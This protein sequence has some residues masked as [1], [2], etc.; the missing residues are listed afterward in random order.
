MN[1]PGNQTKSKN[2]QWFIAPVTYGDVF[3]DP[4]IFAACDFQAR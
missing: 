3:P 4:S 1:T 2:T